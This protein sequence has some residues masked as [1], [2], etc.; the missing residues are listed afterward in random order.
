MLWYAIKHINRNKQCNKGS[1]TGIRK[2]NKNF[3]LSEFVIWTIKIAGVAC[4]NKKTP[5][6]VEGSDTGFCFLPTLSIPA[7]M[8]PQN[9][10]VTISLNDLGKSEIE[11]TN[12]NRFRLQIIAFRVDSLTFK[13]S[14]YSQ[15]Y[16]RVTRM[17][18]CPI[19]PPFPSKHFW[20]PP[21]R[22]S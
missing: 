22:C 2:I 7:V 15:L 4:S 6:G 8:S 17:S 10:E 14:S 11:W 3:N 5:K 13:P 12:N 1:K 21:P 16:H 20:L 19:Y 9:S 18:K